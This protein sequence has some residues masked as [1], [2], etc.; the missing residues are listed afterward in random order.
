MKLRKN[1]IEVP[2]NCFA[3]RW[4]IRNPYRGI[5]DFLDSDFDEAILYHC[6][7]YTS[8]EGWVVLESAILWQSGFYRLCDAVVVV[9]AP[10]AVSYTH[11]IDTPDG[12]RTTYYA[13][14]LSRLTT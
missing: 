7:L 9:T 1:E 8:P 6:L 13:H 5:F 10:E 14:I 3:P 11:L 4:R 12:H 2:K